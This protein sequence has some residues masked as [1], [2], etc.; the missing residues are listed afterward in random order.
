[1]TD[2]VEKQ[3]LEMLQGY[4]DH[5]E[6]NEKCYRKIRDVIVTF[7]KTVG[8]G[9][10]TV[11]RGQSYTGRRLEPKLWFSSSSDLATARDEFSDTTR[12]C[13]LFKINLAPG[14]KYIVV[15]EFIDTKMADEMKFWC[16][17]KVAPFMIVHC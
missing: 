15:N 10:M 6:C 14:T 13:C 9:G 16:Y 5:L 1:M 4:V 17:Q 8:L 2:R 12:G 3:Q 7:G 11:Y